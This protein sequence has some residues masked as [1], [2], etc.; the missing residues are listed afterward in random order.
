MRKSRDLISIGVIEGGQRKRTA[1]E[2]DGLAR[3][4][5]AVDFEHAG[6]AT[7]D[8]AHAVEGECAET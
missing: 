4:F 2:V 7:A 5:L 8:A 6:A 3:D 1:D